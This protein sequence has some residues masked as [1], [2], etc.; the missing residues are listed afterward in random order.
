MR[1]LP[2]NLACNLL[3]A[4][5]APMAYPHRHLPQKRSAGSA[6]LVYLFIVLAAGVGT[7][8]WAAS[9]KLGV[10]LS[11]INTLAA[12]L[13]VNE[14]IG[15]SHPV[16]YSAVSAEPAAGAP[17]GAP[18]CNPGQAPAFD[19]RLLELKQRL[20]DT[21]GAPVECAHPGSTISDT[22]QQTSTGLAEFN[23]LTGT[24]SFTDGWRHWALTPSG[25]V[26]WEGRQAEPP[27]D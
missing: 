3:S 19:P 25:F 15:T 2:A 26:T 9:H 20:G 16:G 10:D 5:V 1:R 12:V 6:E 13:G 22:I 23:Q 8:W 17:P 27:A 14:R 4:Y 21:M 24:A 18:H 7:A 11:G